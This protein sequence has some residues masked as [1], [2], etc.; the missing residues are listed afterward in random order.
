L[1]LEPGP[2]ARVSTSPSDRDDPLN[3]AVSGT[4]D[5]AAEGKM[6]TPELRPIAFLARSLMLLPASQ[7]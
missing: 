6:H 7:G 5:L 2:A 4:F 1:S 3:L